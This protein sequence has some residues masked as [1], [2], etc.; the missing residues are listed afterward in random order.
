VLQ[1]GGTPVADLFLV[2][3][4]GVS[5]GANA[6][7]SLSGS[8]LA[9]SAES[10]LFEGGTAFSA[11]EP[12]AAPLLTVSTPIGL[13]FG[14]Q[15]GAIQAQ[16]GGHSIASLSPI[17][18]PYAG[19]TASGLSVS[20][21]Q[22]L[23][24]LGGALNLQ[25]AVLSAP[26]G[27]VDLGSVTAGRVGL[28][29]SPQSFSVNYAAV[30]QFGDIALSQSALVNVSGAPA[31]ASHLQGRRISLTDGSMVWGQNLG[32]DA[33]GTV[34][35]NASEQVLLTG[36]TSTVSAVSGIVAETVQFGA[37]SNID[38]TTPTLLVR[39]GATIVS[40]SFGPGPTGRLTLSADQ[41]DISGY[42]PVAPNVFTSVGATTFGGNNA[43]GITASFGS[44]SIAQGGYF[45]STTLGSGRGG[46]VSIDADIIRVQ[47][48][49]PSFIP[50]GIAA[51]TVGQGGDS[52]NI[53]IRT[54]ELILRDAGLVTTTNLGVGNAGDIVI[55][56]SERIE[57]GDRSSSFPSTI[58]S[59]VDAPPFGYQQLL[60][61]SG[62]QRGSAGNVTVTAP[63]L[64]VTR[65]SITVVNLGEGDAGSIQIN[66]G[67]FTL[68]GG[69]VD[70]IT[71]DGDGGDISF[72]VQD[73]LLIR[74]GSQI[75]TS[76]E[77]GT[78]NGGNI[79]LSAP[80]IVGTENSDVVAN[81]VGGDGGNIEISTQSLVGLE[82]REQ[83][84]P[85]NDITASSQFGISG[86]ITIDT[87]DIDP[88]SGVV[89]LPTE[90][91]DTSDQIAAG[92]A[93]VGENSFVATGRGG[94]PPKPG[95]SISSPAWSDVR[96]LSALVEPGDLVSA[97]DTPFSHSDNV[98][99]GT[100]A[101]VTGWVTNASG[102]VALV[103]QDDGSRDRFG[104]A[105][106]SHPTAD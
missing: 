47:G 42:V 6:S 73:I 68:T 61:L 79:T 10:V 93:E 65:G 90:L 48:A 92:C 102:E 1:D 46:N 39:D 76:A 60:G 13:Q 50:S 74:N 77:G 62:P 24:L 18:S 34:S 4:N 81:A 44:L 103:A 87:P 19:D 37:A 66:A 27:R 15:P 41:A 95:D 57:V 104:Y 85:A 43:A 25:G 58:S 35:V 54:R 22:T 31:G 100:I 75:E 32:A 71:R 28:E 38:V 88:D 99:D 9:T 70:A 30:E 101:E 52:G 8:F 16:D 23:T 26:G 89:E 51:S 69:L 83:L 82:F 20:P 36:S 2:N 29:R 80:V 21:G 5:F 49:T 7:L 78:G 106:C 84:T 55:E 33:A 56:A 11:T 45:G 64:N 97:P 72:Q 14:A 12:T 53:D 96:D 40:R 63:I 86:N 17:F 91:V 94:L 67:T 98:D 105:T 3:P 59:T